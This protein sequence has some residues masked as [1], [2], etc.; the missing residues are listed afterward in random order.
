MSSNTRKLTCNIEQKHFYL[1]TI[2]TF[3]FSISTEY[4]PVL[5]L[6]SLKS[7]RIKDVS[8]TFP[9]GKSNST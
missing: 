4:E 2:H 5:K 3:G 8:R 1:L 6:Y 9:Q 7:A